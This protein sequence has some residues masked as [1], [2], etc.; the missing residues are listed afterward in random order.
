MTTHE[1]Q[2]RSGTDDPT[3]H[4]EASDD[5]AT[6]TG[7]R[8]GPRDNR[9][10]F[11]QG[12]GALGLLSLSGCSEVTISD[13]G[14]T[15]GDGNDGPDTPDRRATATPDSPAT[16]TP[17]AEPT[18]D[19]EE[20]PDLSEYED[21]SFTGGTA[22]TST[23]VRDGIKITVTPAGVEQTVQL[24]RET[25]QFDYNED[26]LRSDDIILAESTETPTD[27]SMVVEAE[28]VE[29]TEPVQD[30]PVIEAELVTVNETETET[31]DE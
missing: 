21:G 22:R 11:L 4:A 6:G 10:T 19:E 2:A 8:D 15:W 3:E 27:D 26:I 16:D 30:Q 1:T 31:P 7:A 29:V 20:E 17:E 23:G 24:V 14:I 25:T 9:R 13:S 18:A 12:V 28:V 5:A